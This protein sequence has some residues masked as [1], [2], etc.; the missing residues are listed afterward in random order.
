MKRY[1]ILILLSGFLFLPPLP[2]Q[3]AGAQ[4]PMGHQMKGMGAAPMPEYPPLPAPGR[5]VPIGDGYYLIYGFDKSLKMGTVIMKVEVFTAEGKKDTSLE[6]K[7]DADMPSMRG[8]H[9]TGDRAFK[10]SRKGDYLL[11][12][13]IVMPGYWEIKLTVLKGGKVIFRGRYNF[14]V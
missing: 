11:P 5:K 9:A 6:V 8:A 1:L 10:L 12:I 14:N 3:G 13:A 2:I 4:G 7:A